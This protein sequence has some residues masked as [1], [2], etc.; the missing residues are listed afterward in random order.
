MPQKAQVC[1]VSDL[2]GREKT[3]VWSGKVS[4]EGDL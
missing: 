3:A 1:G 2:S 4:F